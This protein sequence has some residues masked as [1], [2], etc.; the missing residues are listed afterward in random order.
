MGYYTTA[1][2]TFGLDPE[3]FWRSTPQEWWNLYSAKCGK[4]F[5]MAQRGLA[6][7][8]VKRLREELDEHG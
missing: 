2:L 6:P 7:G 3:V 1:I 4:R 8:D 5:K